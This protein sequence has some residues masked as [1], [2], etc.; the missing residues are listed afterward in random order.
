MLDDIVTYSVCFIRH[1]SSRV[2]QSKQYKI[3]EH[4]HMRTNVIEHLFRRMHPTAL[5]RTA[6]HH[7]TERNATQ[8]K[9]MSAMQI[10]ICS[11]M[12][13]KTMQQRMQLHRL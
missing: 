7:A 13:Y 5:H 8:R 3:V 12:Q 10:D 1:L 11:A 4:E 9:V 2:A 6:S